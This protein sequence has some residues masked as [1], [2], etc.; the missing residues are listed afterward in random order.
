MRCWT[1]WKGSSCE[2]SQPGGFNATQ[3]DIPR[4][5]GRSDWRLEFEST[6]MSTWKSLSARTISC[7]LF[8]PQRRC[9]SRR[10]RPAQLGCCQRS[11]SS[12]AQTALLNVRAGRRAVFRESGQRTSNFLEVWGAMSVAVSDEDEAMQP[13]RHDGRYARKGRRTTVIWTLVR[14]E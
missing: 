3:C 2:Q 11:G 7:M 8:I 6:Q 13:T 9:F 14:L 12:T 1:F 10:V 5:S 4:A